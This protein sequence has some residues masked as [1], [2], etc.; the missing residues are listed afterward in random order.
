MS[1]DVPPTDQPPEPPRRPRR[2]GVVALALVG[3]ALTA[4]ITYAA[5]TLAYTRLVPQ[6]GS[7]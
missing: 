7:P 6:G 2:A 4:G 1:T 3:L 5:S